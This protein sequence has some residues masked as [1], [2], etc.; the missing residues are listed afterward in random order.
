MQCIVVNTVMAKEAHVAA[1]L[2]SFGIDASMFLEVRSE[3]VTRYSRR[4]KLYATVLTPKK[5]FALVEPS[6]H[7][8]I[9]RLNYVTGLQRDELNGVLAFPA[10]QMA[11]F[12]E[13]H[14]TWLSNELKAHS[15]GEPGKR[16][17]AKFQPY[18]KDA[19]AL[20]AEEK[21]GIKI[22]EDHRAAA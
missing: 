18:S 5:I 21:F 20:Y 7:D 12:R 15:R 16:V 17:K 22:G 2:N 13:A 4:R 1:A 11:Q 8:L 9:T 3:G 10:W 14:A 19:L 6:R